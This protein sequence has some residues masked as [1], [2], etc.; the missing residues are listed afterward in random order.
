VIVNR[1]LKASEKWQYL[2]IVF[3]AMRYWYNMK[4]SHNDLLPQRIGFVTHDISSFLYFNFSEFVPPPG[5]NPAGAMDT[6]G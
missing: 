1:N 5:K 3:A 4:A 6:D 2:S